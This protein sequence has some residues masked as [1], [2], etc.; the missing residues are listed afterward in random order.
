RA[1]SAGGLSAPLRLDARLPCHLLC[2]GG[3]GR[4]PGQ[5]A[6]CHGNA[7][8]RAKVHQGLLLLRGHIEDV[9]VLESHRGRELG[10]LLVAGL[11]ALARRLGIYKV[12]LDC[13]EAMVPFY[14]K[15]GLKKCN[16][17]MIARFADR[18]QCRVADDGA[19]PAGRP[20]AHPALHLGRQAEVRRLQ[21]HSVIDK[22]RRP[23]V[24]PAAGP[25]D[26]AVRDTGG[27]VVADSTRRDY[28]PAT[29]W[30]LPWAVLRP[31]LLRAVDFV[32]LRDRDPPDMSHLSSPAYWGP[33]NFKAIVITGTARTL[34]RVCWMRPH[35]V[36]SGHPQGIG[37][38]AAKDF[39][40]RGAAVNPGLPETCRNATYV[41][42][43]HS[44][45]GDERERCACFE[46]DLAKL[47]SV[48]RVSLPARTWPTPRVDP[49]CFE[50]AGVNGAVA[51]PTTHRCTGGDERWA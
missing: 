48:A 26:P 49:W 20:A 1:T 21:Y 19:R 11:L 42:H 34:A 4:Q 10:K 33:I 38:A 7:D 23:A 37:L 47:T 31:F 46:L 32:E 13:H 36:V 39:A 40:R 43:S 16:S 35:V 45:P 44:L 50:T 22:Q 14:E 15:F 28:G 51:K 12:S 8:P 27:T 29:S 30:L 18:W 2:S 25:P 24:H 3:G 5:P 9:A 17:F 41:G 6:R